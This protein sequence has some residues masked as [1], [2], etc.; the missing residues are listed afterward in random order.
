M[1][2]TVWNVH[3][4]RR[5]LPIKV[6][7][8]LREGP[9]FMVI[10]DTQ[11]KEHVL[12]EADFSPAERE[13]IKTGSVITLILAE[14]VMTRIIDP[15]KVTKNIRKLILEAQNKV[16]GLFFVWACE[17]CGTAGYVEYED[18][19]DPQ[20]IAGQVVL[21][22]EKEAKEGCEIPLRIFDHRGMEQPDSELFLA[23]RRVK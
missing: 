4:G 23:S 16:S 12:S 19:D 2:M 10:V 21:A 5:K 14:S 8:V 20:I 17:H 9:R 1:T 3:F 11:G 7:K 15:P 13:K 18:G 22:H 6:R